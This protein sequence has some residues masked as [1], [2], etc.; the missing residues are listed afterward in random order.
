MQPSMLIHLHITF[1][2][3]GQS[4]ALAIDTVWPTSLILLLSSL[5]QK[6]GG[7]LPLKSKDCFGS[8]LIKPKIRPSWDH[9]ERH[10]AEQNSP[11]KTIQSRKP[12][13]YLQ[14]SAYN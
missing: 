1:G 9:T 11:R 6:K 3:H 14:G 7:Q 10:Q 13:P 2:L 12:T 4:R 8:A 5:L